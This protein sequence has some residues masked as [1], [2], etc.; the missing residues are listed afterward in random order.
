MPKGQY[1]LITLTDREMRRLDDGQGWYEEGDTVELEG[2]LEEPGEKTDTMLQ[3][4][5]NGYTHDNWISWRDL[6]ILSSRTY[7]RLRK[8]AQERQW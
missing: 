8:S 4:T 2:Y 3:L 1:C 7:Q 5:V 6:K